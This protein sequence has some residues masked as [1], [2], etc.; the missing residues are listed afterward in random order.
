MPIRPV[1]QE[2]NNLMNSQNVQLSGR[3]ELNYFPLQHPEACG[4]QG[5]LT[6]TV[7][8]DSLITDHSANKYGKKYTNIFK[9]LF[10]LF[11]DQTLPLYHDF[12]I[13]LLIIF[14]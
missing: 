2:S 14:Y 12:C 8:P 3:A 10:L 5:L 4:I 7:A 1:D 9:L 11:S 13:S 6:P